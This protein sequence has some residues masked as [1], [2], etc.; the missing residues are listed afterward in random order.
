[1]A[2]L[3]SQG[4]FFIYGSEKTATSYAPVPCATAASQPDT[5]KSGIV[6][7]TAVR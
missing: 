6:T 1:M 3:N 2:A 4:I 7:V 5:F